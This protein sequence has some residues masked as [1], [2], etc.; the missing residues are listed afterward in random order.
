[1]DGFPRT[2]PQ[3]E[4]L[5]ESGPRLDKVINIEV[6]DEECAKRLVSRRSC[7]E[8]GQIYN[9]LFRSPKTE[10]ICDKCGAKL[11]VRADDKPETVAKR[12]KVYQEQTAPLISYYE[13]S[14]RLVRVDGTLLPE[15]VAKRLL[16]L[17]QYKVTPRG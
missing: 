10:G 15:V 17:V 1:L 12:L 6:P 2:I 3:A 16:D 11:I 7:T 5:D 4:R 13:D 14:K 8:C 9:L